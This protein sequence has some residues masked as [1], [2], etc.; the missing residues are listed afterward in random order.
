M[1][2]RLAALTGAAVTALDP[3]SG[4]DIGLVHRARLGDGRTVVAKTAKPGGRDT[5]E[6]E[7]AMLRHMA[8]AGVPV[9]GVVAAEPGLLVI[10]AV[11][12]RGAPDAAELARVVAA[13]HGVERADYGFDAETVFAGE[14]QD[15]RPLAGV[16]APAGPWP[17]FFAE[18][19]L[20]PM[21]R[22]AHDA[23]RLDRA[24]L[25]RVEALAGRL[26]RWLP[27]RPPAVLLHGDL[28][29]GNVLGD[30]G[31]VSALIDPAIYYGH[32]EVDLAMLTLFGGA[33]RAFFDAYGARRPLDPG[34]F[35]ARR[36][37]YNLYPLLFHVKAF[38]GGYAGQVRAIL[39]RFGA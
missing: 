7:A 1:R 10:E 24:M 29:A 22:L 13:M 28:W 32:G 3:L 34:F 8:A 35:E 12:D 39:D 38:G 9:P 11:A 30:R 18:R 20:R 5:A 21:A 27:A 14:R 23:G 19:R 36:D 15:N 31:R 4:G 25:G 2:E 6:V 16:A 17:A 26:D 37:L 33:G